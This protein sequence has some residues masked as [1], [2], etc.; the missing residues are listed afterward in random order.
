MQGGR[1]KLATAKWPNIVGP[2]KS[3]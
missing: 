1:K 3:Y 2:I